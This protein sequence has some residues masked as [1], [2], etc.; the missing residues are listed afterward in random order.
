MLVG[1]EATFS[2]QSSSPPLQPDSAVS[3]A[4]LSGD[5][6]QGEGTN[7]V[8]LEQRSSMLKRKRKTAEEESLELQEALDTEDEGASD[9]GEDSDYQEDEDEDGDEGGAENDDEDAVAGSG[10]EIVGEI[11]KS[12]DA[13]KMSPE[14][15]EGGETSLMKKPPRSRERTP[16][17]A[18]TYSFE[19]DEVRR[20]E[21]KN[22]KKRTMYRCPFVGCD[23]EYPKPWRLE[24]HMC[25][26]TGQVRRS[27][28]YSLKPFVLLLL[29]TNVFSV[30]IS[31]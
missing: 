12:Q 6:A 13:V 4:H 1:M 19:V 29:L 31:T 24:D 20:V 5:G 8:T 23:K 21:E 7:G 10:R 16:V 26:H 3:G 25:S 28:L 30:H 18:R 9:R 14:A 15:G 17:A 2:G 22:G 11:A 27:I